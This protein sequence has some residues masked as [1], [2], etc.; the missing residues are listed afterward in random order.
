ME[1]CP[2]GVRVTG[3]E[4][5]GNYAIKFRWSDGHDTGIFEFRLLRALGNASD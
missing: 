3:A 2:G 4:L 1:V 5:V